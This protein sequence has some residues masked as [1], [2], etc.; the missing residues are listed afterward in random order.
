M[1][2]TYP[3]N[4]HELVAQYA[5]ENRWA[6]VLNT[7]QAA[8]ELLENQKTKL[9]LT[10][11][12]ESETFSC[13]L[14]AAALLDRHGDTNGTRHLVYNAL[15]IHPLYGYEQ[16]TSAHTRASRA[17]LIQRNQRI[18]DEELSLLIEDTANPDGNV[19]IEVLAKE[20]R[21]R[22]RSYFDGLRLSNIRSALQ[23]ACI[24]AICG[25]NNVVD[26]LIDG[27]NAGILLEVVAVGLSHVSDERIV[28]LLE[29]FIAENGERYK[30]IGFG[31]IF[32]GEL[33]QRIRIVKARSD[34]SIGSVFENYYRFSVT[35]IF[36][37]H[38]LYNFLP[39]QDMSLYVHDENRVNTLWMDYWK[40]NI[41]KQVDF[42]LPG[43]GYL[44]EF[45]DTNTIERYALSQQHVAEKL[46]SGFGSRREELLDSKRGILLG[47]FFDG[48]PLLPRQATGIYI[49][50]IALAL[51][52]EDFIKASVSWISNPFMYCRGFYTRCFF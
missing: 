40:R 32:I 1:L 52:V 13:R 42:V 12:L 41:R 9:I 23:V 51:Q 5:V 31:S 39:T 27:F 28:P 29:N 47:R 20:N 26:E 6:Q 21:D 10:E 19:H 44:A 2:V 7:I 43:A 36:K 4:I 45:T 49:D 22:L 8:P 16:G 46:I 14:S 33:L 50:G 24:L 11:F 37:N 15:K 38:D 25:D 35:D 48:L 30:S 18:G 3:E 17:K 34:S